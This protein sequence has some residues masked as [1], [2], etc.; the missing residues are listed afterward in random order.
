VVLVA[1]L[2]DECFESRRSEDVVDRRRR[3]AREYHVELERLRTLDGVAERTTRI[4]NDVGETRSV[5]SADA[6]VSGHGG[7][8]QVGF[9][10]KDPDVGS[11]CER[12]GEIDG[13]DGLSVSGAWAGDRD[14]FGL[15][16]A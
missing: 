2:L 16:S 3:S 10:E 14:H 1:R 8:P 4:E 7:S 11:T 12:P 5:L 15:A 6:Q 13:G 9:D